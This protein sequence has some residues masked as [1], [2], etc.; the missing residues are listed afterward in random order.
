MLVHVFNTL[1][2]EE[3]ESSFFTVF[4]KRAT[5]ASRLRDAWQDGQYLVVRGKKEKKNFKVE[6]SSGMLYQKLRGTHS[7]ATLP[8]IWKMCHYYHAG[9]DD[10]SSRILRQYV[11]NHFKISLENVPFSLE[12]DGSL[13]TR[14]KKPGEPLQEGVSTNKVKIVVDKQ[15]LNIILLPHRGIARMLLLLLKEYL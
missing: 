7:K 12:E 8:V 11:T 2:A 15:S 4:L 5:K 9:S 10:I 1:M 14:C 3:E 13:S 6:W